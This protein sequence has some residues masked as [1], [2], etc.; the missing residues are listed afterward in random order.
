[1]L[2]QRVYAQEL[3]ELYCYILYI[4]LY[5]PVMYYC[6]KLLYE[7]LNKIICARGFRVLIFI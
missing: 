2:H 1:M 6:M 4:G 3:A 7:T 5:F